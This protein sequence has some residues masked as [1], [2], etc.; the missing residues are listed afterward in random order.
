MV[1]ETSAGSFSFFSPSPSS[2][3]H[4]Y[5]RGTLGGDSQSAKK[6]SSSPCSLSGTLQAGIRGPCKILFCVFAYVYSCALEKRLSDKRDSLTNP[7]SHSMFFLCLLSQ[8]KSP[9][10]KNGGSRRKKTEREREERSGLH[11][12]FMAYL[13]PFRTTSLLSPSLS[14]YFYFIPPSSCSS[15]YPCGIGSTERKRE[16][17]SDPKKDPGRY[18]CFD[19]ASYLGLFRSALL[20][21][22]FLLRPPSEGAASGRPR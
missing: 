21:L 1:Q 10:W 18:F 9:G 6:F 19:D 20:L 22:L 11:T 3:L 12:Q 8:S 4:K 2:L 16:L 15:L 14:H 5:D 17:G 7:G 13:S